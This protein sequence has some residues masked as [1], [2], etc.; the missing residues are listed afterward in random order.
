MPRHLQFWPPQFR[1][2]LPV[3]KSQLS[4]LTMRLASMLYGLVAYLL[5]LVSATAL[6]YKLTP[7]E[8]AC[9]FSYVEEKGAKLAFYFAVKSLDDLSSLQ[10]ENLQSSMT[11]A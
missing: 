4:R 3:H 11:D 10:D 9:F 1:L 6:T 2:A 8:K 7:N 5:S